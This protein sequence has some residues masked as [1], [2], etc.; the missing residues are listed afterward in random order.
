MLRA[1]TAAHMEGKIERYLK[2]IAKVDVLIIDDF[3]LLLRPPPFTILP[4]LVS[5]P[6]PYVGGE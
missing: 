3:L 6:E 2:N 4:S 5:L 1:L